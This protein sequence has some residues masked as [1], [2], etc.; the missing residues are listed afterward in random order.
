MVAVMEIP[1]PVG[2][3]LYWL[4]ALTFA[5]SAEVN[6]LQRTIAWNSELQLKP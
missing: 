6:P 4:M 5:K 2:G 1:D 3:L